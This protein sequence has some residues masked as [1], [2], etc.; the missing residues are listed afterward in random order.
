VTEG[1][2]TKWALVVGIAVATVLLDLAAKR[3][4][5]LALAEGERVELL[6]FL[7]LQRTTNQGVAFGML[8]GR[9]AFIIPAALVGIAAILIY[10]SLDRRT[11]LP[12]VAGGFL[13]GGTLGNL[14]QRVFADGRVTDF[15]RIPYWPTFNLADIWIVIGVVLVLFSLFELG[16]PEASGQDG[17]R[18]SEEAEERRGRDQGVE[19]GSSG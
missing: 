7:S 18:A 6:P 16:G 8:S 12:G 1:A 14:V 5:T 10:V 4:A 13:L 19:C 15:I 2:R 11:I 9:M 3:V 17:S